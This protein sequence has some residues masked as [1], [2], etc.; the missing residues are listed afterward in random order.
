MTD[1]KARIGPK[2]TKIYPNLSWKRPGADHQF[3]SSPS[4]KNGT[5]K[6][7]Q[8]RQNYAKELDDDVVDD[9]D[10]ASDASSHDLSSFSS[11]TKSSSKLSRPG[12]PSGSITLLSRMG[13]DSEGGP[14]LGEHTLSIQQSLLP[15]VGTIEDTPRS[16]SNIG[17]TEDA[18]HV[19]DSNRYHHTANSKR[20]QGSLSSSSVRLILLL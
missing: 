13:L 6:W 4:T 8:T 16:C 12:E 5:V 20:A 3:K 18:T 2:V 14:S 11:P 10:D 15:R 17:S 19:L 9:D 1:L 7:S